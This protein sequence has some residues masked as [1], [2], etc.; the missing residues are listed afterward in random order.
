MSRTSEATCQSRLFFDLPAAALKLRLQEVVVL[1]EEPT[2]DFFDDSNYLVTAMSSAYKFFNFTSSHGSKQTCH[3]VLG[4]L[5]C[6]MEPPC[7]ER[8]EN[9]SRSL[10]LYPDPRPGQYGSGM[11]INIQQHS[12]LR[13]L[14]ATLRKMESKK[15]GAEISNAFRDQAQREML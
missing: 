14:F 9:P 6:L 15:L 11:V 13:S 2:A 3:P 4:C 10:I 7:D 8:F 1:P 5:S 12:L